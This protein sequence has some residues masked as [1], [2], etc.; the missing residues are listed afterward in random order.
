M[1]PRARRCASRRLVGLH[2]TQHPPSTPASTDGSPGGGHVVKIG[3]GPRIPVPAMSVQEDIV[4][5]LH[6]ARVRGWW[7]MDQAEVRLGFAKKT[8]DEVLD[9]TKHQDD[10]I[11]RFLTA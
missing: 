11:G 10:K 7:R 4:I 6:L 3:S 8:Y 2:H 5:E 1:L 9:A